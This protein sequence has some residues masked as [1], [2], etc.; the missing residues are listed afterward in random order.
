MR[1]AAAAICAKSQILG[2]KFQMDPFLGT[3]LPT[4][5][6]PLVFCSLQHF[7]TAQFSSMSGR[8]MWNSSENRTSPP[9]SVRPL[10]GHP[11][12]VNFT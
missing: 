8:A 2:L 4:S 7:T 11:Q 10:R 3:E 12:S 9:F 6:R 5:S 1:S